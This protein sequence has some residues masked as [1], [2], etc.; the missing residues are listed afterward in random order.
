MDV[1]ITLVQEFEQLE[2][3]K[4]ERSAVEAKRLK[5]TTHTLREQMSQTIRERRATQGSATPSDSSPGEGSQ[6]VSTAVAFKDRRRTGN[7]AV[8]GDK[9][10]ASQRRT[11]D[12]VLDTL[13]ASDGAIVN[14][15]SDV[16]NGKMD[17]WEEME[18]KK[19][20]RL[21]ELEHK[22]MEVFREVVGGRAQSQENE[23]R[24]L[25]REQGER[26]EK[27]FQEQGEKIQRQGER[28]QQQ[29]ERIEKGFEQLMSAILQQPR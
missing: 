16:E 15:I 5:A 8:E 20:D 3:E 6:S 10:F 19:M 17:R 23:L 18:R 28:I 2:K 9:A 11:V 24:E 27:G 1:W 26:M 14:R 12:K 7:F 29:G 13:S 25:V 22:K 4:K 21:E